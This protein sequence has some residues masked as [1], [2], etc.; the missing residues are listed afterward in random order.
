V[1]RVSV[2]KTAQVQHGVYADLVDPRG[3]VVP[4]TT[5]ATRPACTW[6]VGPPASSAGTAVPLA[7]GTGRRWDD[8]ARYRPHTYRACRGDSC[9]VGRTDAPG[10]RGDCDQPSVV[11]TALQQVIPQGPSPAPTHRP[12]ASLYIYGR[13]LTPWSTRY[14]PSLTLLCQRRRGCPHSGHGSSRFNGARNAATSCV[15]VERWTPSAALPGL[16]IHTVLCSHATT[17][18]QP[19]A[20][21]W[22]ACAAT[23]CTSA[24]HRPAGRSRPNSSRPLAAA[25]YDVVGDGAGPIRSCGL[26]P[27][28]LQ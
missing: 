18:G 8:A 15:I 4:R 22:Q 1:A 28:R 26:A 14:R 9:P 19:A 2:G 13:R 6:H 16:A 21:V 25:R 23:C 27:H 5:C 3:Q 20:A 24:D 10:G 17:R 11:H 12:F 7:N